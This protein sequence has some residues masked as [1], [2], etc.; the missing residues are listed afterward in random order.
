[1]R[2]PLGQR[3]AHLFERVLDREFDIVER[4]VALLCG[5]G[6]DQLRLGHGRRIRILE[7]LVE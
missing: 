5:Q 6:F 1:M 7:V 2:S 4:Q 3:L